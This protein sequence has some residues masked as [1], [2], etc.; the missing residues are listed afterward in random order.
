M[1]GSTAI[2]VGVW[3]RGAKGDYDSWE[4]QGAKGWNYKEALRLFQK[5][6]DT[7]RGKNEYRGKNG[8]MHIEDMAN[9]SVLADS[10]I[11]AFVEAGFG[12]HAD[13]NGAEPNSVARTQSIYRNHVRQTAADNYLSPEVR[14]RANLSVIPHTT[15][16][17]VLF[18]GTKVVGVEAEHKGEIIQIAANKEVILSAGAINT[19]KIL[20]LSGVGDRQELQKL[21]VPV[22]AHVP[23][24]GK[25]LSDHLYTP[26]KVLAPDGVNVSKPAD[27]SDAAVMQWVQTKE[28]GAICYTGN[29]MGF[30]KVDPKEV[31]PEYELVLDYN[32]GASGKEPEFKDVSDVNARSGYNISIVQL[33]PKSRGSVTLKST[34]PLDAPVIDPAYFSHPED[35]KKYV[36][37]LRYV[38]QKL[39]ATNALKTYTQFISPATNADDAA[40]E[41]YIRQNATTVFHP[42]GT[43]RMGS[44]DDPMTVVD[45]NLRVREVQGLRVADASVLPQVNRGHTMAPSI[46]VGERLA[47]LIKKQ[48]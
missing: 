3:L 36:Q 26:I 37:A 19:P 16:Y 23:G 4:E 30:M 48:F 9:A 1:G 27:T 11:S 25:N 15:V 21:G 18:E 34:N 38:N 7:N 33:Q 45:A 13:T 40:L 47:E 46:F 17:R 41:S 43:A 35:M 22:V 32:H 39:T 14:K 31:Y 28:G 44:L 6:E 24:V 29:T 20:L 12:P 42:A 2:N 10:L 8:V 5:I